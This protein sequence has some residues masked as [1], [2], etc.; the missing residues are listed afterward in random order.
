MLKPTKEQERKIYCVKHG[1][2]RFVTTT[3]GYY[4][5]GRCGDKVGDNLAS[6]YLDADKVLVIGCRDKP[7]KTCDP[8]R[9]SL[10]KSDL[11]ILKTLENKYEREYG[12]TSG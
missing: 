11:K 6:V 9:K 2:A 8:A 1:H 12:Q 5:C 4:Y 7:C 10:N 3:W